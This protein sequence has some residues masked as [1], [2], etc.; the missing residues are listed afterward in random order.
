MC[1]IWIK[2]WAYHHF[3]RTADTL[4][5]SAILLFLWFL[6]DHSRK[7]GL[8]AYEQCKC[9]YALKE[10]SWWKTKIIFGSGFQT[11]ALRSASRKSTCSSLQPP[12][13]TDL[14]QL[15][16]AFHIF[17]QCPPPRRD[18]GTRNQCLFNP[19]C[20]QRESKCINAKPS[21]VGVA[22]PV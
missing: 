3:D 11:E 17:P 13:W 14:L 15:G 20:R 19:P 2:F 7:E 10:G 12:N 16:K 22:F 5:V 21:I 8:S 18:G 6:D 1:Q 9:R 4:N